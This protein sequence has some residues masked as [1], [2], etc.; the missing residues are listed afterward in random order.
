MNPRVGK[1]TALASEHKEQ[2]YALFHSCLSGERQP[3]TDKYK[4]DQGNL[5]KIL[6]PEYQLTWAFSERQPLT[7]K[8]K[9]DQGNLGKILDPE[10]QLVNPGGVELLLHTLCNA[11]LVLNNRA[12][13]NLVHTRRF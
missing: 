2:C 4:T 5:G 10:Y 9:T 7:D 11:R 12:Y 13:G 8:Y 6:D 3:L 1:H